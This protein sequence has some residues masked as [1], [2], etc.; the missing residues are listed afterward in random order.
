MHY[1]F[2]EQTITLYLPGGY[3][4][5]IDKHQYHM[6]MAALVSER[7]TCPRRAVGCILV[8]K[9]NHIIATGYNGLPSGMANCIDVEK[10]MCSGT[11]TIPGEKLELCDAVH[12]EQN[13]LLQCKNVYEIEAIYCTAS[14]CIHCLKLLMNTACNTIYYRDAYP[15]KE[16]MELLKLKWESFHTRKMI[17]IGV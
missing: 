7:S 5:R 2:I 3:M 11:R 1:H 4:N 6:K 10:P 13:A 8:N 16:G 17:Q 15:S 9:I 14:P 12:A